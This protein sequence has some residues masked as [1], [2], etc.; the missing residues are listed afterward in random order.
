MIKAENYHL[1]EI[2]RGH[3]V[4][5]SFCCA[6]RTESYFGC[7]RTKLPG[8]LTCRLHSFLEK[9]AQE[10]L[11]IIAIEVIEKYVTLSNFESLCCGVHFHRSFMGQL[12]KTK[13]SFQRYRRLMLHVESIGRQFIGRD[14]DAKRTAASVG[15]DTGSSNNEGDDA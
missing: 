1:Y 11:A 3:L 15:P 9:K 6:K 2:D 10:E 13:N 8:K 14:E 4:S 5:C 7:T 12:I